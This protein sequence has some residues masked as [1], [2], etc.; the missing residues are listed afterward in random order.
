MLKQLLDA[1]R[2]QRRQV[3]DPRSLSDDRDAGSNTPAASDKA[4]ATLAAFWSLIGLLAADPAF[5]RNPTL[6]VAEFVCTAFADASGAESVALLALLNRFTALVN[7][8]TVAFAVLAPHLDRVRLGI[9]RF[10]RSKWPHQERDECLK[11]LVEVLKLAGTRWLLAPV[12]ESSLAAADAM[13][14][15]KF[16]LV[17]LKLASIE[18]R[19]GRVRVSLRGWS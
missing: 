4:A 11:L 17:V 5:W 3:H 18:V 13:A 1:V 6:A 2:A 8:G 15:G 10:L 12:T 7:D 9:S 16:A 19:G 14:S